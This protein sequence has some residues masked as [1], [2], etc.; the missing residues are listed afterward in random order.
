MSRDLVAAYWTLAGDVHPGSPSEASPWPIEARVEA[1][2]AA[3]FTG[4]GLLHADLVAIEREMS[5]ATL[6]RLFADHGITVVELEVAEDWFA[7]GE[8]RRRSEQVQRDLMRAAD[9]LGARDVKAIGDVHGGSWEAAE[10]AEGF[11]ALCAG[12]AAA[13]TM[14]TL[15][16]MPFSN[17]P[18]VAAGLELIEAAGA[19]N[20]KLVVDVWHVER[21]GT[22]MAEVAAL[23]LAAVGHVELNDA[24]AEVAGDLFEDS[25]HHR[26]LPGEGELDL[27][28]FLDAVAATGY[29]GPIGVE[30]ISRELRQMPLGEA[31][32]RSF[33]T[34]AA[35]LDA[36]AARAGGGAR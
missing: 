18:T 14:V 19:E 34:T 12:A 35:V 20:G 4:L 25:T 33:E 2:A 9:V 26:R 10:M 6:G 8:R 32:R 1:A 28:G 5:L 16:P 27:D 30:M 21:A 15:E 17:L 3:G 23:P 7:S 29:E 13:G 36:H 31:A 22:P 11:A 24:A